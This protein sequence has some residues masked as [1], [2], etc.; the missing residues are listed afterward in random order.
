MVLKLVISIELSSKMMLLVNSAPPQFS[1]RPSEI[2]ARYTPSSRPTTV[3]N[4]LRPVRGTHPST[5][6]LVVVLAVEVVV[7]K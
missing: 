4:P 7:V 5:V 1:E 2:S 6:V 3:A